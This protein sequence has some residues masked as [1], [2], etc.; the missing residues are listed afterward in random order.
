MGLQRSSGL[1]F[2]LAFL[3]PPAVDATR[4]VIRATRQRESSSFLAVNSTS[5]ELLA[6]PPPIDY[7]PETKIIWVDKSQLPLSV[8]A[9]IAL[10]WITMVSC[11]PLIAF[12]VDPKN[13]TKTQI[14]VTAIMWIVLAGG[15]YLFCNVLL[16]QSSHFSTIRSLTL[17]ECVYFMC[18]VLTTV[19]YGDITPA[20]PR[21]QVFVGLYVIFCILIIANVVSEVFEVVSGVT[22]KMG[23]RISNVVQRTVSG[24]DLQEKEESSASQW[25]QHGPPELP[26]KSLWRS[27]LVYVLSC[28]VGCLFYVWYPGEEKTVLQGVYMSVI[29]LSTVGFGVVTPTTEGG[30]VFAAFWLLFGSTALVGLIGSFTSLMAAVKAQEQYDPAETLDHDQTMLEVLPERFGKV[31]F[32]K[33]GVMHAQLAQR[34]DLERIEQAFYCLKPSADGTISKDALHRFFS[35]HQRSSAASPPTPSSPRSPTKAPSRSPSKG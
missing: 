21:G 26:W 28:V 7:N 5:Q 13:I 33:F 1:L 19:G 14:A 3:G 32:L 4:A 30:K 34:A 2:A 20:K 17:V 29:S 22:E 25:M 11:L 9:L 24:T 6:V 18:Q 8:E 12:K 23:D 15:V 27:F 10:T 16:F 31:H 35:L